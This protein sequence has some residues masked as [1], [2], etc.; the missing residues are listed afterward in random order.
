MLS[1]EPSPSPQIKKQNIKFVVIITREKNN[2][3]YHLMM[4]M[5]MMMGACLKSICFLPARRV[6]KKVNN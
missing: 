4:M 3:K 1:I 5:M 2:Q 6:A